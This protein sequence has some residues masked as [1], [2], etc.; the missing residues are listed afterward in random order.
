MNRLQEVALLNAKELRRLTGR[1]SETMRRRSNS[2]AERAE[3]GA[4]CSEFHSR[5][6]ELFF[7][8]G[9]SAWANFIRGDAS[10]VEH[11]LAFLEADPWSFRSGYHK[12]IVW[13]RLKQV[14]LSEPEHQRLEAVALQYLS[15]RVRWEFWHMAKYVRLR[16]SLK[17][18]Q[19]ITELA[20]AADRSPIAIKANWL[21]L[22]RAN[23]PVRRC[24][25]RELFRTRYEPMYT[26][27]LDFPRPHHEG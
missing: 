6:G 2:P 25:Q 18:W 26:P 13:R 10:Y 9:E 5:F 22:V 14:L 8:G 21:L 12:Q 19:D 27:V 1:I 17:F 16:G 23:L 4:A 24:I 11:A 3:W 20:L 7:P 15:K